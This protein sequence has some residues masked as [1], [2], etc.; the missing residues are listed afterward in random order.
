MQLFCKGLPGLNGAP[1]KDGF[2]GA[3]GKDGQPGPAGPPGYTGPAGAP[4]GPGPK[5]PV[6]PPGYTGIRFDVFITPINSVKMYF[7]LFFLRNRCPR[8]RWLQRRPRTS[9]TPRQG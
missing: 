7:Y 9:R 6:G 4:G 5:G 8:Q 3:P 2:P 1:G